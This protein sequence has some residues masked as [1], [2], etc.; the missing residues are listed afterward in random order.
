VCQADGASRGATWREDNSIIFATASIGTGLQLVPAA[1][2]Q[3]TTLTKPNRELGENDHLW[4]RSLPGGQA[5]LFTITQTTG[6]VDN[7]HIAVY[8]VAAGTYKVVLKGGSQAVYTPSGHLVYVAAGGL[9]AIAFDLQ[10]LETTGSASP[11]LPKVVTLPTGVAE[12]DVAADGTL[13]YLTESGATAP[14]RRTLVWVDRKGREEAIPGLPERAYTGTRISPDGSRVA[15]EIADQ[16]YDVWVWSFARSTLTR[17][18]SDQGFDSSPVWTPDGAYLIFGSQTGGGPGSLFR[19]RA[20]GSGKPERLTDSHQIQIPSQV[21]PNGKD[22]VLAQSNDPGFPAGVGALD[23][24]LLTMGT[25]EAR[26][27]LETP[28]VQGHGL[29]S[30]DGRWIAYQST[31]SGQSDI[32]VGP[33]P[34]VSAGRIQ[35]SSGGGAQPQW[36]RNGRELFYTRIDGA[37]MSV[38]VTPGASWSAGVAR[39]IF[40]RP[41]YFRGGGSPTFDVSADGSRFLMI[42]HADPGDSGASAPTI[43]IVQN[44]T[45]ELKRLVPTMR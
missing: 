43:V 11:A 5:V 44:W 31:E 28:A 8:D 36:A 12:F 42:K 17:V 29:V 15:L 45:E 13:I 37:L 2:G 16:S 23:L 40:E 6:G 35:V 21:L 1:G 30:P 7:A 39:M 22:I 19:Q 32:F 24:M 18:T 20:D 33:F 38:A 14:S 9:R 41:Y 3:P 25:R 27:L 26:P 4:P 34:D 10:R